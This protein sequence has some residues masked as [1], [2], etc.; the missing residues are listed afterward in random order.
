[1][2]ELSPT[3]SP[4]N[5]L[6]IEILCKIFSHCVDQSIAHVL[7]QP[8]A[9][10]APM[11]LCQVCANWRA[12]ALSEPSLWSHLRFELPLNWHSNGHLFTWDPEVFVRRLEWL[13]WWKRNLRSTAP[14]L[15]VEL[16]QTIGSHYRRGRLSK[17]ALE[18][19]L[20]L[21]SSAQYISIGRLYRYLVQRRTEA[22]YVVQVHPNAH[23]IV[24][25]WSSESV[26]EGNDARHQYLTSVLTQTH[27]TLRHLVIEHTQLRREDLAN[28][29][30]KWS[31]LTHLSMHSMCLELNTWFSFIRSLR[32]LQSGSF[33]LGLT[34]ND[35]ETYVRPPVSTLPYAFSLDI[36][37]S[38]VNWRATG[39]NPL[40][41]VFD[42]L[43]L[44]ALRTLSLASDLADTVWRDS[45]A[46]TVVHAALLSAPAIT[47]LSLGLYFLG[48][49]AY[50][51]RPEHFGR[52][53]IR[54]DIEPLVTYAP[55]LESLTFMM[56]SPL[57]R[58][59]GFQFIE[60]VFA[61]SRWLDLKSPTSTIKE[62]ILMWFTL[63]EDDSDSEI[64]MVAERVDRGL[65]VSEV[66]R[67]VKD[68]VTVRFEEKES[69][70]VRRA[71]W[72]W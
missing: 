30:H 67:L 28:P 51:S 26:L 72:G 56:E 33:H 63:Q 15:Q 52:T 68:E 2:N 29:L 11:L 6:P 37:A 22:G 57:R 12:V 20:E 5:E 34:D 60:R 8:N 49:Q 46:I 44:P 24:A 58:H 47:K 64:D 54:S 1:M 38:V 13:K 61:S 55:R 59:G 17:S 66:R 25:I 31:T 27:S 3:R 23:T 41:A 16:R 42:N 53:P 48:G 62:V 70:E 9:T 7:M 32:A 69:A 19:L 36:S 39:Q 35:I 4:I 18:F 40:K 50:N 65:L 43:R 71:A 45:P 21:T 10:I 14:Y